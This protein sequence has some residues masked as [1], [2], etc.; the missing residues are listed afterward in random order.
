MLAE[1]PLTLVVRP[2]LELTDEAFARLCGENPELRL[3]RTADGELQIM[4]PAGGA[5]GGRNARLTERLVRWADGVGTGQAFDSSTGYTLP[6]TAI[7]SPDASWVTM[8]RL[9]ALAPDDRERFLPICPDFV[10]ELSSPSD[11][12]NALRAKMRE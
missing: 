9:D 10:V 5:T 1:A 12:R 3:E 11:H 8:E 2:A 6:S 4:T 7:R